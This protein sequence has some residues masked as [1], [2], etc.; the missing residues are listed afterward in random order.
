MNPIEFDHF[1]IKY[2]L[3]ENVINHMKFPLYY[4]LVMFPLVGLS[5]NDSL[6]VPC[7]L[8]AAYKK[9]RIRT[10]K[11]SKHYWQNSANYKIK[12]NFDPT[13]RIL[14]GYSEITYLNKS[15]DT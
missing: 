14:N 4:I 2:N 13:T 15:P 10:V 7:N 1:A 9:T 11:P 8:K 6:L 5:Q 12:I 3:I